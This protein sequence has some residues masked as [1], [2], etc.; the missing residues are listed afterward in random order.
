MGISTATTGN[1]ENAQNI[2]IA[3]ALFT[4]EANAPCRS[5]IQPFKLS[6]GQKQLTVPKV[7]QMTAS[8]LTDGVDMINS[9]DIGLTTTDLTTAEVALKVIVTKK[10]IRQFNQDVFKMVGRQMGDAMAR[11][12]DTDVIALFAGLNG[13]TAFGGDNKYFSMI[14]AQACV[15]AATASN[16]P[17]PVFIVHNPNAVGYLAKDAQ[18]I[19]STYYMG[20]MQGFPEETLRNYWKIVLSGVP[21]FQDGNIGKIAGYDS[22]YGVIASKSAMCY[23]S[24]LEPTTENEEDKSL[25]AYE[26]MMI[27][28]YG[29]FELDDSYGAPLQYEIGTLATNN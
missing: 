16:F 19:G 4:A 1:L 8:S 12:T 3:Q 9:Q 7:G 21:V 2:M 18:G 29:V 5:L 23:V 28:D 10:L 25:R 11:K 14:N 17:S 26:V 27:S 13:G 6:Q 15:T 20:V 22:G 24:E